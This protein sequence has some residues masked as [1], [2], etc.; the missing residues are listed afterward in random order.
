ML[1]CQTTQNPHEQQSGS[2]Q[3][4]KTLS[5]LVFRKTHLKHP[6]SSSLKKRPFASWRISK[7]GLSWLARF[8]SICESELIF[9]MDI[10]SNL[11]RHLSTLEV[12]VSH[13][14]WYIFLIYTGSHTFAD[15]LTLQP[16]ITTNLGFAGLP[17]NQLLN[18]VRIAETNLCLFFLIRSS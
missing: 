9:C 1:S 3:G 7:S 14:S 16:T 18:I 2:P 17:R 12:T 13:G 4:S 15:L 5:R 11:L 6:T 10:V 8:V